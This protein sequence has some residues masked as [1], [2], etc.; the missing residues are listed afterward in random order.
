MNAVISLDEQY[1]YINQILDNILKRILLTPVTT[2]R[3]T[4]YMETGLLDI[5]TLIK[6]KRI[7]MESRIKRGNNDLMKDIINIDHEKSWKR[8]TDAHKAKYG[9]NSEDL[10]QSKS[11]T[12]TNV[13]TK[14]HSV[15]IQEMKQASHEKS[16]VKHLIDGKQSEFTD[17]QPDY[18]TKLSRMQVSQ[19]FKA[20]TRM[21][22]CKNNF[23][24]K[25]NNL[26]CR[27]CGIEDETQE[28][29]LEKCQAIHPDDNTRIKSGDIFVE[30]ANELKVTAAK[31]KNIMETLQG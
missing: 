11:K 15:F 3:E 5:E 29:I 22:D 6:M 25:Y 30:D 12:K 24:G 9:I 14:I 17:I 19:I 2:P 27:R 31:I 13:K 4:L 8:T 26:I 16:K 20:R 7:N 18:M 10:D 23:R 21:L 1:Y 28:H